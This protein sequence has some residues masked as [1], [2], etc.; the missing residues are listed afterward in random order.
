M[1]IGDPSATVEAIHQLKQKN[2]ALNQRQAE[3]IK[4]AT[5]VGITPDEGHEYD[6]RRKQDYRVGKEM[7]MLRR[8]EGRVSSIFVVA[9]P[10][11]R[12]GEA[13][14]TAVLARHV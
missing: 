13:K 8:G 4:T 2:H 14:L 5:F 10:S 6:E 7:D 1:A 12:R 9:E 3:A 11:M